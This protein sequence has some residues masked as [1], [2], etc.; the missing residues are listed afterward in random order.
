MWS[1]WLK[2]RQN[3]SDKPLHKRQKKSKKETKAASSEGA[4]S[5]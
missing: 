1:G 4:V 5:S 3:K 2:K